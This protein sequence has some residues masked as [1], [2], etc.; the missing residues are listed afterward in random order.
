MEDFITTSIGAILIEKLLE[1]VTKKFSE[2]KASSRVEITQ[3][4]FL[5]FKH[6]I[7]SVLVN[8]Q[9]HQSQIDRSVDHTLQMLHQV[10]QQISSDKQTNGNVYIIVINDSKHLSTDDLKHLIQDVLRL[11]PFPNNI[12]NTDMQ[13]DN[14]VCCNKEHET[15]IDTSVR[16]QREEEERMV[17]IGR[18]PKKSRSS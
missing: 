10:I 6:D 14:S 4:E 13:I 3:E 5:A 17:K 16:I 1:F 8:L 18:Y 15:F 9:L 7:Q 2:R 12:F 11:S